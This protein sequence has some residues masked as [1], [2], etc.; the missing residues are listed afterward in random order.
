M[1]FA[2]MMVACMVGSSV[3][4]R[5]MSRSD[6]KVE[7]YMQ[8]VFLASAA[9]LA[10]PVLVGN[11]G[12]SEGERGGSMSFGGKIQML[13]FLVFEAMVGIFWPSM[14][15]MRS[16]YVP[17]EVRSTV[18]NF[19]RIPLNLFVCL[20]LYNVALFP[21]SAMFAMCS[22]FLVCAAFLQKKLETLSNVQSH[23]Y[24]PMEQTFP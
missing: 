4:S 18:M 9:S 20:I 22:I 5:I 6:M 1:I 17:E 12:M 3:A 23:K 14:M 11:M 15:K 10:V 7:R 16:Q 24:V 2:T 8:L 21:L 13:A 19:F